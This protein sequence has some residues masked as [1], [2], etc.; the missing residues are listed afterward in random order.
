MT[1]AEPSPLIYIIAGE[2]SGDVLGAALMR[3]LT[4]RYDD[5][6]RFAGIGG[7]GM[8]AQGLTSLFPMSDL[9]IMGL[10]EVVPSIPKVLRRLGQTLRDIET[11]RPAVV[12]TIDSWGFCGRLHQRLKIACPVIPRV[13]YVAPMVWAWKA[14]RAKQLAQVLDGLMTLLP[15]EP[16]YFTAEGLRTEYVGHSILEAGAGAGDGLDFRHRHGISPSEEILVVLPGSRV[17]ETSRLLPVFRETVAHLRGT[18]PHLRVVIPTVDGVAVQVRRAVE[19]WPVPVL[20]I[21]GSDEKY[22]AFNAARAAIA[23][24]GTVTLELALARVPMAVAYKVSRLSAFV[25]TRFLGLKFKFVSLL[26][27]LADRLIVPEFL[28]DACDAAHLVPALEALLRDSPEREAQLAGLGEAAH[29]LGEN[30][31]AP[32]LRAADFVRSFVSREA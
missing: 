9:S 6:V 4:I 21:T 17:T 32:S 23:A 16:P 3:A 20:V 18:H 26:N 30:A 5:K 22:A 28:Q 2:P 7:E 31:L 14:K 13:H 15:F 19:S 25:A 29:L 24:S 12:V 1:E 10:A 8:V 27:I 11:T